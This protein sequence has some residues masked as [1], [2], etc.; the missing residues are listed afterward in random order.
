[1]SMAPEMSLNDFKEENLIKFQV[2]F[3]HLG[4]V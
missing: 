1:M 4:S 2:A 3:E